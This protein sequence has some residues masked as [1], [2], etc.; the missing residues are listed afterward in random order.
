MDLHVQHI[1]LNLQ[2]N[3]FMKMGIQLEIEVK[4]QNGLS[5][6][7]RF[8]AYINYHANLGDFLFWKGQR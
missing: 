1:H 7:A 2:E 4:D 8:L 3:E 5:Y 6:A